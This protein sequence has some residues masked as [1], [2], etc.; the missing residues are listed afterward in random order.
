MG[1]PSRTPIDQPSDDAPAIQRLLAFQT[2]L[3]GVFERFSDLDESD[4]DPAVNDA[5]RAIGT[6]V[7]ADRAYVIRYN[8]KSRTTWMTHEWCAPGIEP[9]YGEEQGRSFAEAPK[10]QERL[11]RFEVNEIRDVTALGD[12]WAEDR[13]YLVSQGI[14]AILEVPLV[15]HDRL[16]GVIGLDST[17]GAIPWT[18]E[19]VTMLRAVAALFAQVSERRVTGDSVEATA[20][21][22]RTT[23]RALQ[24]AEERFEALVDRL[25]VSVLRLTR[26][27]LAVMR[28]RLA[29]GDAVTED[30]LQRDPGVS[31]LAGAVHAAFTDGDTRELEFTA[32]VGGSTHWREVTIQPEVD[33]DGD[34]VSLLLVVDDTTQRHEHEAELTRAVTHDPLTGLANRALVDGLLE[35]AALELQRNAGTFT[36]LSI[37]LDE[38]KL[39]NDSL[40]HPQGDAVLVTVAGRLR[41]E[42]PVGAV[43]A[44]L[45]GDEFA[46]LLED[47]GEVE[48]TDV[49]RRISQ[50]LAEPMRIGHE[51]LRTTVSVGVAT[52]TS[53]EQVR[54]LVRLSEVAMFRA[55]Q[56]GRGNTAVFE[57]GLS[58][59]VVE[60][61]QR[62][63]QLRRAVDRGEFTVAFQPVVDLPT[64]SVLGAEALV[65]WRP[66]GGDP[67]SAAEF[68]PLAERNGTIVAIGREVLR[69]ACATTRRWI[70]D[71]TVVPEF[72]L[73]VNLSARQLD[74]DDCV[75]GIL[76]TLDATGLSPSRLCLEITE[77]AALSD[78]DRAATVLGDARAAGI[79]ISVDD[80][81]TGYGSLRLL[82]QLPV[83]QLKLDRS[84]V[85]QLPGD[86]TASAV[87]RAVIELARALDLE[88]VAEGVE[89]E[90]QLHTLLALGCTHAQGYLLGRPVDAETFA[91]TCADGV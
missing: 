62:D 49:A 46:V 26:S 70:E 84:F 29:T 12:D 68:I 24:L 59:A 17:T 74:D 16:V 14:G 72:V 6:F 35:R 64:R 37:D 22:L 55:K 38:F 73:A 85:S 40:G 41:R 63:Q 76:S 52:A 69:S 34:V 9:S 19:D 71:G 66:D 3:D 20:E 77:T 90:H 5:L 44:R 67:V 27:G 91:R 58:S 86:R 78:I 30:E 45:G 83:D 21:Q 57:E 36:V 25:P 53:P 88:L 13:A 80:F 43:V 81:G 89:H 31:P 65:R 75:E 33:E 48:A 8:L 82:Q 15:R 42:A 51:E 4:L 79:R 61:L 39:V 7:R 50:A 2:V 11:E 23:V 32:E 56:R 18:A 28:N 60:L 54:E 1:S 10:Q 47:H 87:T